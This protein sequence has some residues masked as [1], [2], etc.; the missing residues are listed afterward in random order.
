MTVLGGVVRDGCGWVARLA[1]ANLLLLVFTLAGLGVVGLF[2]AYVAMYDLVR[3]WLHRPASREERA[4]PRFAAVFRAELVRANALG[5]GVVAVAAVIWLSMR[6]GGGPAGLGAAGAVAA[7]VAGVM[8]LVLSLHLPFFLVH[9]E[10]SWWQLV[11]GSFLF[12]VLRPATTVLVLL[13]GG[14]ASWG[15][16]RYPGLL[17]FFGGSVVCLCTVWLDLRA[18]RTLLRTGGAGSAPA[19]TAAAPGTRRAGAVAGAATRAGSDRT[20]PV[21]R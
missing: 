2:P 13:S 16:T 4:V 3:G 17:V 18:S 14:V 1:K 15:M 6:A 7:L 8:L 12:G 19:G 11:R 9:V 10:G 21:S 20:A 5:Y